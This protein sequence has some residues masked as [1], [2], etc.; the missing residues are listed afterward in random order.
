[1]VRLNE[2]TEVNL[3][4]SDGD[5][6]SLGKG[7]PIMISVD[8]QEDMEAKTMDA[9]SSFS[10]TSEN[11]MFDKRTVDYICGLLSPAEYRMSKKK[12]RKSARIKKRIKRFFRK[13][14]NTVEHIE[15][16]NER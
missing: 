14:Y 2:V 1:M 7:N 8:V 4:S 5:V 6:I 13:W 16:E 12:H 11:C 10:I 3:L 9:S 15:I